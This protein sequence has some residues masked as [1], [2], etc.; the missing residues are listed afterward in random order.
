MRV[1]VDTNVFVSGV[2]FGDPPGDVLS[3][4]RDGLI[5][6][7]VSR[8]IVDEYVKVGDRL[9]RQFPGVDLGPALDLVAAAA[10]LFLA[11]PLPHAVCRDADDDKFL[12]CAVAGKAKY[13]VSGDRDLLAIS[14]WQGV[15][16]VRPR[17]LVE[18]LRRG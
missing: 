3:A 1:V 2:F 16:V 8:E 5:E 9:S 10:K 15:T 4:W 17:D 12:A 14:S 13:V 6:A 18:E 11:P 7:L